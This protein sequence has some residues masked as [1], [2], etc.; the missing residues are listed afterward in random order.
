[1]QRGKVV[2]TP[3]VKMRAIALFAVFCTSFGVVLTGEPANNTCKGFCFALKKAGT[4]SLRLAR[5][6][7]GCCSEAAA[8]VLPANFHD[9]SC[10]VEL[11]DV[12]NSENRST[13]NLTR[14]QQLCC[15]NLSSYGGEEK[16]R[17]NCFRNISVDWK[18]KRFWS[19][20]GREPLMVW[21]A[22]RWAFLLK[23]AS[24]MCLNERKSFTPSPVKIKY[25][26]PI[27][28]KQEYYKKKFVHGFYAPPAYLVMMKRHHDM[29]MVL[30]ESAKHLWVTV[31]ICI[32]WS[33]ISGVIIWLLVSYF[34][35]LFD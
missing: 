25:Q 19:V 9:V 20:R 13:A 34:K 35:I 12:C 18:E 21:K 32:M 3:H 16:K 11:L 28:T 8:C 30:G 29:I 33:L 10:T 22:K 26:Y 4:S 15:G 2:F 24:Q 27:F 1:M 14:V 31:S 23:M 6:L 7:E 17:R 5:V